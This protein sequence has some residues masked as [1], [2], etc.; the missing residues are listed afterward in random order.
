M[1]LH[2]PGPTGFTSPVG[3]MNGALPIHAQ[4]NPSLV[5]AA[6]ASAP[7][8]VDLRW[9]ATRLLHRTALSSTQGIATASTLETVSN[10]PDDLQDPP[11]QAPVA[12]IVGMLG[13]W[14]QAAP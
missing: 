7:L 12:E 3:G 8:T 11:Q 1:M 2:P 14:Q 6:T 13:S 5:S 9:V 10:L 4:A